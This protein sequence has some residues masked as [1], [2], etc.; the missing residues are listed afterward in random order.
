MSEGEMVLFRWAAFASMVVMLLHGLI[1]DALYGAQASPLLFFAPA[2]VIVVTR[3]GKLAK[4]VP[5]AVQRWRWTAGVGATAVLLMGLYFGL[6]Q[7]IQAQWAANL[8][9]LQLARAELVGWPTNQWDA[10]ENL[11]RF[12]AASA[13]FERALA[14]DPQNRTAN[15]RLGTIAMVKRDY[16]TAVM[17]LEQ[18]TAVSEDYRGIT[19]SLGYSYI[20]DNQINLALETLSEIPETRMEMSVYSIWWEQKNRQD[21][22]SKASEMAAILEDANLPIQ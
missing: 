9:A 16:E 19:K 6:S 13:F 14:I 3:R 7:T 10:G 20:W 4:L 11:E 17:Y 18:A 12:D 15:H 8:G 5:I 22:A 2:M 21:L 1:D